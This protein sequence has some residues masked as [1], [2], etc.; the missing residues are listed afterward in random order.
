MRSSDALSATLKEDFAQQVVSSTM[1]DDLP[2]AAD[3][4]HGAL[5]G[6]IEA[7]DEGRDGARAQSTLQGMSYPGH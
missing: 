2:H 4:L 5:G 3:K 1:M 7:Y 6:D